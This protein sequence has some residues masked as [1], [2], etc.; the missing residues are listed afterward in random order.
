MTDK[1][2]NPNRYHQLT[3][4]RAA[5]LDLEDKFRSNGFVRDT[6]QDRLL[7]IYFATQVDDEDPSIR[8]AYHNLIEELSNGSDPLRSQPTRRLKATPEYAAIIALE[9]AILVKGKPA[10]RDV[11]LRHAN[12]LPAEA[13]I[14][15]LDYL[16]EQIRTS[17]VQNYDYN[18]M[19]EAV[20]VLLDK[21]PE[22]HAFA[23]ANRIIF[24]AGHIRKTGTNADKAFGKAGVWDHLIKIAR[25]FVGPEQAGG[26]TPAAGPV[27]TPE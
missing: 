21:L 8:D 16:A 5:F 15:G 11:F 9:A 23:S 13:A 7:A 17:P 20:R 24:A 1:S 6:Q 3:D 14:P 22:E 2:F 18:L 10:V 25:A 19:G 4:R 12:N 27:L 26:Q